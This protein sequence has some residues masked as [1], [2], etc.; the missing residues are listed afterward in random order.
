MTISSRTPDGSWSECPVC[1]HWIGITPSPGTGNG[2]CPCCG[3]LLWFTGWGAVP[4]WRA[5]AEITEQVP[6]AL[7]A[8]MVIPDLVLNTVPEPVARTTRILPIADSADGLTV[9]SAVPVDRAALGKLHCVL[10]RPILILPVD[11]AWVDE[12]I[13][14][15]Y[16]R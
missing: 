1:G 7:P 8:E 2:P 5:D 16:G 4:L 13:A 11:A 15:R 3:H 12:Q 10:R 14:S 6:V 9:A